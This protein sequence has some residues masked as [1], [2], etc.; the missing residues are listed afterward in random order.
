MSEFASLRALLKRA[1][2]AGATLA[3]P[4]FDTWLAGITGG[5]LAS[6]LADMLGAAPE[7]PDLNV[8]QKFATR[9]G[10]YVV[11]QI[12]SNNGEI[13][14]ELQDFVS[15]ERKNMVQAVPVLADDRVRVCFRTGCNLE[16]GHMGAHGYKL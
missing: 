8:H 7:L 4:D 12:S 14:V 1:Y 13:H 2:E 15:F 5:D 3:A 10:D 16:L 6:A 9:Q 11:T